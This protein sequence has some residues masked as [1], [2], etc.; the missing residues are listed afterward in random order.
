MNR[1]MAAVGLVLA[2][3]MAL[4][5]PA[6]AEFTENAIGCK[7]SARIT[8]DDGKTYDVDATDKTAVLPR[9]GQ[10][11][12]QGSITTVTHDHFGEVVI[13][14]GPVKQKLGDWGPRP[15]GTNQN[16]KSGV[17]KIPSFMKQVPAGKYDVSGFHE[18]KEGRCAGKITVDVDGSPFD[19]P[20]GLATLVLTILSA[21]GF[22]FGLLRGNP[23]LGAIAGLFLGLFG[24]LQLVFFKALTSG[25][26]LFV[27]LPVV[28]LVV[29]VVVGILQGRG[30]GV[31]AVP[32]AVPPAGPP[33]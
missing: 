10:A 2:C 8:S 16:A 27:I 3:T 6:A 22:V 23:V 33:A 11:A 1:I 28:L 15:N 32:P 24:T 17:K 19:T 21:I 25:T 4:A 13:K 7:G 26:P 20:A 14:I 9:D 29:G 12:W 5:R 18:G 31:G 30:G